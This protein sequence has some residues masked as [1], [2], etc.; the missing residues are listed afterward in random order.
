M[1]DQLPANSECLQGI[2]NVSLGRIERLS[3]KLAIW[4]A[5][6]INDRCSFARRK[7]CQSGLN[8]AVLESNVSLNHCRGYCQ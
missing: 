1:L 2:A 5:S 8:E 7:A 3:G 4:Q 6:R